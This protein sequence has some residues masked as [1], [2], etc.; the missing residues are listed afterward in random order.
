MRGDRGFEDFVAACGPRLLRSARLLTGEHHLAEDLT[1][2]TLLKVYL[3]WGSAGRWDS[4]PAYAQ[5]VLYTTFCGWRGRRWNGER[6]TSRLPEP[7][8]AWLL[9]HGDTGLVHS[10]LSALP[11]QQRA[12]VVA[13]FYE[14][15]TVEQTAALLGMS[16]GT[17]K[18][19]TSR[20]L[21]QLRT[22]LGAP[23]L[24]REDL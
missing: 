24:T 17:V 18:S 21:N 2:T 12:V 19:H 14:D 7:S 22:V 3:H 6:P 9:P 11:R 1:Q 23:D 8:P 4:P 10:A 15:L 16:T 13:R 5:R 20:A